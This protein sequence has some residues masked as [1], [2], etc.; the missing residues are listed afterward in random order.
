M[1]PYT[2]ITHLAFA[3]TGT[4]S[5]C[6]T[7]TAQMP[8]TLVNLKWEWK[9]FMWSARPLTVSSSCLIFGASKANE[10]LPIAKCIFF[11]VIREIGLWRGTFTCR[12]YYC[13]LCTKQNWPVFKRPDEIETRTNSQWSWHLLLRG[14]WH[15]SIIFCWRFPNYS[16]GRKESSFK[17]SQSVPQGK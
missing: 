15:G 3:T 2:T 7:H 10:L 17:W 5:S 11:R 16:V 12:F 1:I 6:R 14:A 8:L 4:A 9:S 13:L